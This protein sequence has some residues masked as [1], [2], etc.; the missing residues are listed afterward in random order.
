MINYEHLQV[1]LI[2]T[3]Y[4]VY[5]NPKQTDMLGEILICKIDPEMWMIRFNT[6][7][8]DYNDLQVIDK[9]MID[10]KDKKT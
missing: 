4:H 5:G 8:L 2:D 1:R 9:I 6:S 3:L 7:W 10:I